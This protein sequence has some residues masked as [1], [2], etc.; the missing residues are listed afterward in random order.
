MNQQNLQQQINDINQKLSNFGLDSYAGLIDTNSYT[1]YGTNN[2]SGLITQQMADNKRTTDATP[3][4]IHTLFIPD[5]SAVFIEC[6]VIAQRLSGGTAGDCAG[7]IRRALYKRVAGADPVLVGAVQDGFI[8]ES[9]AA[10][11]CT[12]AVSGKN[13]IVQ[14][15]GVAATGIVWHSTIKTKL[16]LL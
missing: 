5:N 16:L 15:T 6:H 2:H 11:D 3:T 7:Y 10:Y 14:V 13:V 4:T 1:Y 12:L 8:A 9:V